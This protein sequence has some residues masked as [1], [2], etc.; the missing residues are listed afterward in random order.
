MTGT[1]DPHVPA[2]ELAAAI[3]HRELSPVEVGTATCP[4]GRADGRLGAMPPS[5]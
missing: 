3:R 5:G 2:L 1:L 4:G